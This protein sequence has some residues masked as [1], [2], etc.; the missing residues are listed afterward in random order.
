MAAYIRKLNDTDGNVIFPASRA[1]AIF[2]DDDSAL[3]DYVSSEGIM[4]KALGDKNGKDISSYIS[5]LSVSGK[6]ITYTRGDGSN[7][8]ITTQDT[9]YST[10]KAATADAAGGVGLVP[11]PASGKQNQYLRG[12]GTW[13][14]PTNT[15]YSNATT[16]V[17]GLMSASDKAK[18]DGIAN[19]ANNYSHPTYTSKSS[20]LYK[21]T[22]DGTGHVSAATAVTKTDITN[23]GI[24]STNTTYNVFGG[25]TSSDD[26]SS[27]LVPA[28]TAGKQ[29]QYLRGDGTWQTPTNTTYSVFKAASSTSSGGT[30]LVPAPAAGNQNQYLRGD[31]TWATPTNTTYGS[32][33]Q[34]AAGLMS[35]ADKT[36]LDGIA[37]G[38]NKYTHPSYTARNSGLY[39][40]TVD[41]TGHVSGVTSVSK[42]DITGLG[43][44]SSDTTYSAF[45]AATADAAGGTGLVPA[46]SAGEN[47][48]YLRGDG[49]WATPTNTTYSNATNSY[50]GL[51]SAADKAKL[52][53]IDSGAN[54]VAVDSALSS[55]STNP[56]QNKVINTALAGKASSSHTHA[57]F[58][59]SLNGTSQGAYNGSSAKSINITPSSIGAATSGHT[60]TGMITVDTSW[61]GS[62]SDIP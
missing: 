43:I 53:G 25:A 7:G 5:A 32:A 24:P 59:I 26:G 34:D 6:T 30:G 37:S 18:L 31:G 41:S 61:G 36:K 38:A 60:H 20:G 49:T 58:T 56:V 45:K 19:G 50:A 47:D 29:N 28:P 10:F 9:T 21:I 23:L 54:Y 1:E 46:P 2:F 40:I 55:T 11:A 12:D 14:T 4:K 57:N 8:T 27:G 16:S 42:A 39:K 22:V 62:V 17:A 51:M 52:D 15:T 3:Q 13:A 44:P 35:A 33:T 48:E